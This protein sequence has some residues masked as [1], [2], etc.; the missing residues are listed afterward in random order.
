MIYKQLLLLSL[1]FS[2]G[3]IVAQVSNKDL[4]KNFVIMSD[5]LYAGKYEVSNVQ[6]RHFLE[7]LKKQNKH[8]EWEAARVDS[9]NWTPKKGIY[10]EK[11]RD[12]Y[13]LHPAY[14]F[15]PVVNVS[16]SSATAY[17]TWLTEKYHSNPKRK[18]Q[19]VIFRLPT[20]E[21]WESAAHGADSSSRYPWEG[22]FLLDKHMRMQCNSQL[23]YSI[24]PFIKFNPFE[25]DK[26]SPVKSY[27]PNSIG[28]YNMSGN[29]AEMVSD[30]ALTKGGSWQD[31][32]YYMQ[33]RVSQ[34]YNLESQYDVGFRVFMEILE[35]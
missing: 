1:I 7:D 3:N 8:E 33:I 12:Y 31:D 13:H 14:D 24:I 6:Y 19:K 23:D 2:L 18:Y 17:C 10:S 29:V 34:P 27:K 25:A 9:C 30:L 5:Q 21:E 28:L 35:P 15:Y 22:D 16:I 11:M 32:S 20:C 4:K 26:F